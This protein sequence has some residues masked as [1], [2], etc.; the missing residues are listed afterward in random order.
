M[1]PW[2]SADPNQ[3]IR[4]CFDENQDA[5]RVTIVGMEGLSLS[6]DAEKLGASIASNIKM[7]EWQP[8]D[9]PKDD[10]APIQLAP[11][12]NVPEQRI[13]METKIERVEVPFIV[14][15]Q[16]IKEIQ[17]PVIQQELKIEYV[18]KPVIIERIEYRELKLPKWLPVIIV[19][20]Q[21]AIFGIMIFK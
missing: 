10:V 14:E 4:R 19:L 5:N 7:P 15:R 1:N 12:F 3:I 9:Y 17:I 20:Q 2:S 18:E 21:I 13:I 6:I 16:V 8:V 11:I